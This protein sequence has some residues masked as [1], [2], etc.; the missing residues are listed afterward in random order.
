M[1][2]PS[3]TLSRLQ[4]AVAGEAVAIRARTRLQPAGGPGDKVFPPTY[5]V[6]QGLKYAVE[7]RVLPTGAS[8]TV[9]LDSVQSQANRMEESLRAAWEAGELDIPVIAVDFSGEGDIADIGRITTLD[10]PHRIADAILR[11]SVTPAGVLFRQTPIGQS[12]THA[13]VTAATALFRSCPA[14][15]VFGVWDSTGPKGGLGAKFPRAL[16]SEIVAIDAQA[17]VKTASRIDPLAIEA[18]PIY[19]DAGDPTQYTANPD[20][21]RKLASGAPEPFS[22]SAAEADKSKGKDKD[23]KDEKKSDSKDKE[24]GKAS[25]ANHSNIAPSIDAAAGGITMAYAT[26]T[27]VLSLVGLRRLRFPLP[28]DGGVVFPPATEQAARTALAALGIAAI[29]LQRTFGQDLRSRCL[30]VPE[31][32]TTFELLAPDGSTPEPFTMDR[33]GA[34]A[35]VKEAAAAAAAAGLAWERAPLT[36]K[37]APRLADLIRRSRKLSESTA[38]E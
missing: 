31:G 1:S 38:A 17:G 14:A 13:K 25:A 12:F 15:L 11:D 27:S 16:V 6:S 29:V 4:A 20:L 35:L 21:A 28:S 34:L 22:R 37:P 36:L 32:P 8:R 3:L 2:S 23:A 18:V 26:Q 33:A 9:L 10:M 30:L 7:E 19:I 24:K 5:A